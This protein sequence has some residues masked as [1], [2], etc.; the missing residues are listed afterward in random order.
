MSLHLPVRRVA[1]TAHA[2]ANKPSLHLQYLQ[3]RTQRRN[4]GSWFNWGRT[5][6]EKDP[7]T[8]ELTRRERETMVAKR[9]MDRTQ[10]GSIFEDEIEAQERKQKEE[11]TK[12]PGISRQQAISKMKEHV[13][14]AQNPD[15]RWRN[16]YLRK[17]VMQMVRDE[18][19][20]KPLSKEQR[21]RLT[22]KQHTS[23][24]A[25][26][27][28]STKKLVHL[29]HQIVGKSVDDAITQMRFSKKKMAR[30][31]L[32][33]LQLARD[34]AIAAHG[35]GLG[36]VNKDGDA[37]KKESKKQ[38]R[39]IKTKDGKS[40]EVSDP[41]SLYV[42]ESWVGRGPHMGMRIQYHARSRMSRM[43]RPSAYLSVVL[44][45]EKTRVRQHDERIEK[46]A[47]KAPWVHLPN[48]PITAQRP[49]YTW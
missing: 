29:T 34:T 25:M 28:T 43:M 49:Y 13:E 15:P 42:D 46:E 33:Q 17:K 38:V 48:R 41:T 4:A 12:G 31:V 36:S 40:I 30:E 35:M 2:T 1:A 23:K 3:P 10:G 37:E 45:E 24:S 22:E 14:L 9:N 27:P 26:L 18:S 7:L 32:W 47:K 6:S 39:K 19:E 16:R 5:P 44:K 11:S 8:Q 21:I 20:G